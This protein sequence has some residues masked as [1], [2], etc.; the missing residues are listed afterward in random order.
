[1]TLS[2]FEVVL[3]SI[4]VVVIFVVLVVIVLGAAMRAGRSSRKDGKKKKSTPSGGAYGTESRVGGDTA[5]SPPS[6]RVLLDHFLVM[7]R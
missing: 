6:D 7:L 1:V 3:L 2:T 4:C 5:E